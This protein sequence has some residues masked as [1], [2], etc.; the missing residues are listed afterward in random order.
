VV[1]VLCTQ[2]LLLP[3]GLWCAGVPSAG[4][5]CTEAAHAV[6]AVSASTTSPHPTTTSPQ[7]G[8][9]VRW[10]LEASGWVHSE[11]DR[12]GPGNDG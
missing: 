4:R 11:G 1:C 5:S 9:P 6:L 12:G 2:M 7:V 10:G 3:G 8:G